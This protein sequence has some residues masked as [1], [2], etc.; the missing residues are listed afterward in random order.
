VL[1]LLT[2]LVL[3]ALA[4]YEMRDTLRATLVVIVSHV[5][6]ARQRL[7]TY[8]ALGSDPHTRSKGTADNVLRAIA[9]SSASVAGRSEGR[10]DLARPLLLAGDDRACN[11]GDEA[12]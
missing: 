11:I 4:L 2:L 1:V 7:S 12:L 5:Q 9:A 10:P 6:I 8:S 3:L